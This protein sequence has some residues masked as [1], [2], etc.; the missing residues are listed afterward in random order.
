MFRI[1]AHARVVLCVLS[2]EGRL[3][4]DPGAGGVRQRLHITAHSMGKGGPAED[5][6]QQ[7]SSFALRGAGGLIVDRAAVRTLRQSSS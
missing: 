3:N 7:R 5:G 4:G 6:G 1:R 2:I